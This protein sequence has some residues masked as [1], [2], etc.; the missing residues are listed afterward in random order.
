MKAPSRVS[1]L[2]ALHH[3]MGALGDMEASL[4]LEAPTLDLLEFAHQIKRI[5]HDT[6]ANYAM[7]AV[8]KNA[9]RD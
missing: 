7:L 1:A 4:K 3:H 2:R 9:A 8:M 5:H 6:I